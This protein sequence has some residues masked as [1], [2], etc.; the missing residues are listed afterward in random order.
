MYR[1]M[2]AAIIFFIVI[3]AAM[4]LAIAFSVAEKDDNSEPVSEEEVL[5]IRHLLDLELE[6]LESDTAFIAD[7]F[8][9]NDFSSRNSSMDQWK[10]EETF[11]NL[12]IDCMM[13]LGDNESIFFH[14]SLI[15]G[16]TITSDFGKAR[17]SGYTHLDGFTCMFCSVPID[18]DHK[19]VL[20]KIFHGKLLDNL[21]PF[22]ELNIDLHNVVEGPVSGGI[23]EIANKKQENIIHEGSFY[24][25]I[26]NCFNETIAVLE[27]SK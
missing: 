18:T 16:E 15:E 14:S 21:N 7:S 20:I 10:K 5:V 19:L 1:R 9:I 25:K 22:P 12:G 23:L 13:V 4:I 8:Q 26:L 3:G 17:D 27:L 6:E 2:I 11:V 24:L